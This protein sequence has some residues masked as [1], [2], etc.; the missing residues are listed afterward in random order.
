MARAR[1]T[2]VHGHP[3]TFNLYRITVSEPPLT[4]HGSS[5]RLGRQ[6]MCALSRITPPG[7]SIELHRVE[8]PLGQHRVPWSTVIYDRSRFTRR[9]KSFI[10]GDPPPQPIELLDIAYGAAH[11]FTPPQKRKTYVKIVDRFFPYLIQSDLA[12]LLDYVFMSRTEL[13]LGLQL[14][15]EQGRLG[16]PKSQPIDNATKTAT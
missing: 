8:N 9:A 3:T 5:I 7:T 1:T 15:K 4:F 14:A 13:S 16:R 12:P 6:L 2:Y 11:S 10:Y